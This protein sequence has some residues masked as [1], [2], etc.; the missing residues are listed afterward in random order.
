MNAP[1]STRP[2]F[3]ERKY[4]VRDED[5]RQRILRLSEN[6]PIDELRP[7]EV[8]FREILKPRKLDQNALMWV[9]PLKDIAEQGYVR[10]H[11]LHIKA[12]H[13]IFKESYLPEE[14]DPELCKSPDYQKWAFNRNG[15]RVLIGSTTDLTVKGFSVYLEQVYA[16]GAN[17]GVTFHDNPNNVIPGWV[18]G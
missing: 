12:W 11:R 13:E 1:K 18:R 15:D 14:Y 17:L 5:S 10:G 9:G 16:D 3:P 2:P 6:L 7:L 4:Q 8:V